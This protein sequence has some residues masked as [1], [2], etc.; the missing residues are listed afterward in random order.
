LKIAITVLKYVDRAGGGGR[1]IPRD[2]LRGSGVVSGCI[3]ENDRYVLRNFRI[4][5]LHSELRSENETGMNFRRNL[6]TKPSG[7]IKG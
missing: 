5:I 7:V 6:E 2:S 1:I 3:L 4:D